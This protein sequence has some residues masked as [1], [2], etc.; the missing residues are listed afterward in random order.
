MSAPRYILELNDNNRGGN[1]ICYGNC[2]DI[3]VDIGS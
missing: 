2:S 1:K 3:D